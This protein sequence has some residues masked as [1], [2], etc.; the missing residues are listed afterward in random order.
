VLVNLHY[1]GLVAAPV[2][3]IGSCSHVSKR[4]NP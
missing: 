3:I 4:S 1:R 2:A